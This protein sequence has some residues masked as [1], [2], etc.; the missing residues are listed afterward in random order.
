MTLST[1]TTL[2]NANGNGVLLAFSFNFKTLDSSHITVSLDDVVQGSGFGVVL[3][4]DQD[5][6]PGGT[7]TFSVAPGSGVTVTIEREVP[8]T[9]QVD[10][11][12]YDSFPAETHEAALD[13]LTM[14]TQENSE[15]VSRAVKAPGSDDGTTDF[16]LPVY[17]AG[18]GIMWDQS[19]KKLK[20]SNDD[21]DNITS[22]ASASAASALV[23][24]NNAAASEAD[25][26][27]SEGNALT[28][29]N[30]A[31]VSESNASTSEIAAAGHALSANTAEA[32]AEAAYDSFDD[33]YLGAKTS[34][35]TLDNDG[36]A[37]LTGALY[38]HTTNKVFRVWDGTVWQD[39]F[40]GIGSVVAGYDLSTNIYTLNTA[41]KI[42]IV[43]QADLAVDVVKS[44]GPTGSGADVIVPAMDVIPLSANFIDV[45]IHMWVNGLTLGTQYV[46]AL[47]GSKG[48]LTPTT[49]DQFQLAYLMVQN[50]SGNSQITRRSFDATIGL[51]S[52][53]VFKL[54]RFNTGGGTV[55]DFD[56]GMF[57]F[58]N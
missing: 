41:A 43:T 51:D 17:S 33:R 37:L 11:V 47:F 55:Y 39:A 13:K 8:L 6:S 44:F 23:S 34:N 16:T 3:N 20:N 2:V 1:T 38:W 24:A 15:K 32:G 53:N 7:V 50:S 10:Y 5:N 27:L 49:G 29:M 35:P 14:Q 40:P 46:N 18:K 9:Q 52:N 31:N 30:A 28:Y 45:R 25:A 21:F 4:G 12:P 26:G 19:T 58:G 42:A 54:L 48:S 22:A 57:R 56:I 36:D